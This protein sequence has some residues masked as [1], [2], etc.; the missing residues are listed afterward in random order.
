MAKAA[1]MMCCMCSQTCICTHM[2]Y[3]TY[4]Y[5]VHALI[6][7][8][9]CAP[10]WHVCSYMHFD[11]LPNTNALATVCKKEN[12]CQLRQLWHL[13]VVLLHHCILHHAH[14]PPLLWL[15]SAITL[16]WK[17]ISSTK[18]NQHSPCSI[19]LFYPASALMVGSYADSS[20]LS[21]TTKTISPGLR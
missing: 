8:L 14:H 10:N 17:D 15:G 3:H 20:E 4:M 11:L 9:L 7:A 2:C 19:F 5:V 21:Y 18:V 6:C 16:F 1:H 13:R 12:I